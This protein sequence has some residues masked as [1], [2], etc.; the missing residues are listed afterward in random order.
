[1]AALDEEGKP[2][3]EDADQD[4]GFFS[5]LSA[6]GPEADSQDDCNQDAG[7]S[8]GQDLDLEP[9]C[10]GDFSSEP[11]LAAAAPS[12]TAAPPGEAAPP[13]PARGAD[14]FQ[15]GTP[16]QELWA[17]PMRDLFQ[18]KLSR[19]ARKARLNLRSGCT[20]LWTEGMACK[21]PQ[22]F[23]HCLEG[24]IVLHV[25]APDGTHSTHKFA[26]DTYR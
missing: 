5:P 26:V 14:E 25:I 23:F 17:E 3:G 15:A 12:S 18:E 21:V 22:L 24:A 7:D 19:K 10:S 9:P 16:R 1:M 20:G 8:C 6:E 11:A 4:C 13:A 2:T